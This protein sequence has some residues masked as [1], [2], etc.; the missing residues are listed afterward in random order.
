M[1]LSAIGAEDPPIIWPTI[2]KAYD[3]GLVL[4]EI[5][6]IAQPRAQRN[7]D[8]MIYIELKVN[9]LHLIKFIVSYRSLHT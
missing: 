8:A 4:A 9:L 7:P 5:L 6:R 2:A 3:G 1:T